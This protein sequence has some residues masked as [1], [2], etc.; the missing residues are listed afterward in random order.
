LQ[1]L[2]LFG[3][4]FVL[5]FGFGVERGEQFILRLVVCGFRCGLRVFVVSFAAGC[6]AVCTCFNMRMETCV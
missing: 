2:F 3:G 4:F 6:L 1:L 5:F